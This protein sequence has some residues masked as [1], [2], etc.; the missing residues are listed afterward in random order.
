MRRGLGPP[1][2]VFYISDMTSI[3]PAGFDR[4]PDS[5]WTKKS[6]ES[7]ALGY[8]SVENHGWYANLDL[9][10]DQLIDALGDGD[11]LLDYSG[12]TGILAHRLLTHSARASF[13]IVIV[14]SSPKFLRLA[15]EK[16]RDNEHLAFRQIRFLK[17]ERRLQQVDEVLGDAMLHRGADALVSTNAIH[18]YFGLPETVRSWRRALKP[19][20]KV[21]I[22]SGNIRNPAMPTDEWIIDETVE[23][24]HRHAMEIVRS[25]DAFAAYRTHLDDTEFMAAHDDLRNKYFL[26]VR[27]LDYYTGVLQDEG[28]EIENVERRSIPARVDQWYEF[29]SVYHEG[30]VGWVGGAEKVVGEAPAEAIVQD[31]QRL[32]RR[33]MEEMFDGASEFRASWTYITAL[34]RD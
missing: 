27:P 26:P 34:P 6:V 20:G 17:E 14:D 24:I 3:W 5:D 16:F 29:L 15:L 31:R 33:A 19:T 11:I 30:V 13:G 21:F 22:Q 25:D 32:M 1:Y 23:V 9:T 4:I 7:L 28:F 2:G 10:V 8:D 18:L 12:G